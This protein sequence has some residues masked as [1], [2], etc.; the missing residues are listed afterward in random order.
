MNWVRAIIAA[1]NALPVMIFVE[2]I[3][4]LINRKIDPDKK[5]RALLGLGPNDYHEIGR[6]RLQAIEA[7]EDPFHPINPFI[8]LDLDAGAMV[9]YLTSG[10]EQDRRAKQ[11]VIGNV[12][13][14]VKIGRELYIDLSSIL[15][16]RGISV[17]NTYL[18]LERLTLSTFRTGLIPFVTATAELLRESNA[19]PEELWATYQEFRRLLFY[20][21]ETMMDL[22]NKSAVRKRLDLNRKAHSLTALGSIVT[23][24]I[25][26]C[27]PRKNRTAFRGMTQ[28]GHLATTS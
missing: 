14:F 10:T 3:N 2:I 6:K 26:R 7:P 1:I 4:I 22:R 11:I 19:L 13:L 28:H 27:K 17:E 8:N 21:K 5:G 9:R 23:R 20:F 18:A 25:H 15:R 16:K 24:F 12:V